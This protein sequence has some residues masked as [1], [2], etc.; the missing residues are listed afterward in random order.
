MCVCVWGGALIFVNVDRVCFTPTCYMYTYKD[1]YKNTKPLTYY[2]FSLTDVSV[3][4]QQTYYMVSED[5]GMVEVCAFIDRPANVVCPVTF[6]FDVIL[7]TVGGT[8]DGNSCMALCVSV[9][10]Y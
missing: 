2:F 10:L 4:L 9:A 1:Q 8:A 7:N 6:A 5:V 3:S